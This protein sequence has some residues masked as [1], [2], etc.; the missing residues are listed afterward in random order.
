LTWLPV[1]KLKQLRVAFLTSNTADVLKNGNFTSLEK[2][3]VD[4]MET[5]CKRV[6][7]ML[8]RLPALT[9]L[10]ISHFESKSEN[11]WSSTERTE[12]VYWQLPNLT[13]LR[14]PRCALPR[15]AAP[16]LKR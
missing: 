16:R 2:L 13:Q 14:S 8:R 1:P 10:E 15:I 6:G 11:S 3:H 12:H 7:E 9:E 4:M 5:D